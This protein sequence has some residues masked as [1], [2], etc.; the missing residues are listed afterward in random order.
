MTEDEKK[1]NRKIAIICLAGLIVLAII[2]AL[3]SIFELFKPHENPYGDGIDVEGISGKIQKIPQDYIDLVESNVYK[4]IE[5]RTGTPPSKNVKATIR[6]S[7]IRSQENNEQGA[8]L[9]YRSFAIDIPEVRQSYWVQI[10]W[11][12]A[13]DGSIRYTGYPVVI[14][15]L[16]ESEEKIYQDFECVDDFNGNE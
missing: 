10:E 6:E 13:D 11:E 9:S 14:S 1:S 2:L 5:R 16:P 3:P 8:N 15:C 7:S 4:E 12:N